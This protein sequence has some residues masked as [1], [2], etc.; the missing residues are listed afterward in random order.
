MER[1]IKSTIKGFRTTDGAGVSL[2]R[3]LGHSTT[4]EYDPILMLDSF[5]SEEPSDYVAGF[6]E[7]PHR[8]IETVSYI[9]RG[10]MVHKDSMGN[11]DMISDGEVQY[12]NS[13]S[14][15]F[16]SEELPAS[17]RLLGVQLDRKSVV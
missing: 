7:H 13:G 10:K 5:D 11:E 6:P 9:Y 8:G 16:H 12:M 3:V 15:V 17:E 14:G 1:K 4:E 2:V